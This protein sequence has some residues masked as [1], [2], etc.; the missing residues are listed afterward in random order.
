MNNKVSKIIENKLEEF[1]SRPLLC[2]SNVFI[3]NMPTP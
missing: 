1:L 2:T 3:E